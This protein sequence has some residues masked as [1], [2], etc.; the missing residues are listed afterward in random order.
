MSYRPF[1]KTDGP[2]GGG[3][4]VASVIRVTKKKGKMCEDK[5]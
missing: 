1:G 2:G 4:V 3:G 5:E